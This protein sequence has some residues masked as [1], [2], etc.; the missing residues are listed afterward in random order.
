MSRASNMCFRKLRVE[1]SDDFLKGRYF[2]AYV[3][4]KGLGVPQQRSQDFYPL[5]IEASKKYL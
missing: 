3:G 4:F 5:I 2:R 1:T